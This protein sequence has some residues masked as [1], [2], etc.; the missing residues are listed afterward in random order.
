[1]PMF[2][3]AEATR[4]LLHFGAL[5]LMIA[6]FACLVG[7][8][9]GPKLAD[10]IIAINMISVKAILLVVLLGVS[11]EFDALFL[12][13]VALVYALLSFLAV[14]ILARFMLQ[15]KLNKASKQSNDKKEG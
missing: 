7:A 11:I 8:V 6:M 1:M 9:R 14:V 12:V 4:L 13:D 15:V 3:F 2:N 5:F 10:R